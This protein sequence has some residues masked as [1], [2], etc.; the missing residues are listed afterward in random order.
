MRK[1]GRVLMVVTSNSLLFDFPALELG[2]P[3][4]QFLPAFFPWSPLSCFRLALPD[5]LSFGTICALG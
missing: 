5:F 3:L 2:R 1:Q 4:L